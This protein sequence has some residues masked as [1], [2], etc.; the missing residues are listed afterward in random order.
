M[1]LN[2]FDGTEEVLICP[3]V[4][5]VGVFFFVNPMLVSNNNG[6]SSS[7]ESDKSR[8]EEEALEKRVRGFF[9]L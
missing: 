3:E 4:D 1:G 7:E 6:S 8:A 2:C 9:L 5:L